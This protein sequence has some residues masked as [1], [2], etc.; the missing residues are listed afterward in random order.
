MTQTAR[1]RWTREI[2]SEVD[3]IAL[4]ATGPVILHGYDPPAGGRWVESAIPGKLGAFDR[5][6][7]EKLWLSPCEIGYGRGFGA[8][9]G[10]AEDVLV[11]GPGSTGHRIARMALGSGELV[12]VAE[13]DPFDEALVDRD[14]CLCVSPQQVSAIDSGDLCER[15]SYAREG[16]RYRQIAR[17]GSRVFVTFT[18][19]ASKKQGLLCLDAQSGD[20][21]GVVV[22]PRQQVIHHLAADERGVA[23]LLSDLAGALPPEVLTEYLTAL[24]E[25]RAFD[26]PGLALV[27]WDPSALEGDA[28]LWYEDLGDSDDEIPDR[29]ITADSGKLYVVRGAL[30]EVRDLLSG[31]ALGAWTIPGLDERVDWRVAEGAGLLAEETRVSVFE[32]PA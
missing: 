22:A 10:A 5:H 25:E 29:A 8:G 14:L 18:S 28:P 2:S 11:L 30:L 12:D 15:W 24:P 23:L 1:R 9:F 32:L 19:T 31:R 4:A 3:G 26:S 6:T 20:F 21:A 17:V 27:A 16:E 7:G 13:I